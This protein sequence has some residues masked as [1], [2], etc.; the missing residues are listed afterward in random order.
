MPHGFFLMYVI[1]N[2]NIFKVSLTTTLLSII[3][4]LEIQCREM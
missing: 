2:K 4:N 3:Y 1:P